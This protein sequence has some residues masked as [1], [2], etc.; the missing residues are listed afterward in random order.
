LLL[1][2]GLLA[3]YASTSASTALADKPESPDALTQ[4]P[5]EIDSA[6]ATLRGTIDPHGR[7]TL[8][9]FAYGP[10][11]AYGSHTPLAL[12]DPVTGPVAVS[13]RVVGL[14]AGT[15]YHVR[16]IAVGVGGFA[17]GG[18]V[19]FTTLAALPGAPPPGP[20]PPPEPTQPGPVT[21]TPPELGTSVNVA[22]RSGDVLVR[23]PGATA[24]VPLD[25]L[26]SVP[27]GSILDTRQGS[28]TLRTALP[29]GHTQS[30]FFHG[31]LFEVR[32]PTKAQG[33][34]ELVLHGAPPTCSSA[35]AAAATRRRRHRRE[36]WGHD[37]H[38]LF[39]TRG[40]SSVATVR[41]TIWLVRDECD[42]T[43]T[44]V[45]R[46]SVRVFDLRTHRVVIVRA[47]HSYLARAKH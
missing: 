24:S 8:Y 15:T 35:R 41:G 42:G 3:A 18:D 13:S 2:V 17:Q 40:S 1:A 25:T 10:T 28:V 14:D 30:A 23:V 38:G 46:G 43:L 4:A 33:L 27:V 31:G 9:W 39:R 7:R 22:P 47:G 16:L 19:A 29:D 26:S 6:S 37:N 45:V 21:A 32:Q 11:T 5:A 34:T 44:R 12:T 36:L 20:A